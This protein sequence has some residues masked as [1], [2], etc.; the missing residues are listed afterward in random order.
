M[1]ILVKCPKSQTSSQILLFSWIDKLLRLSLKVSPATI[2]RNLFS[3]TLTCDFFSF[4]HYPQPVTMGVSLFTLFCH[5]LVILPISSHSLAL[6]HCTV[7]ANEAPL[8]HVKPATSFQ[9]AVYTSS[10]GSWTHSD[11]STNCRLP[12]TWAHRCQQ[13]AYVAV[14]DRG[15]SNIIPPTQKTTRFCFFGLLAKDGCGIFRIQ[16]SNLSMK[17]W[18][19]FCCDT[20]ERL[21]LFLWFSL[22][23][24]C[25]HESTNSARAILVILYKISLYKHQNINLVSMGCTRHSE[26]LLSCR[27]KM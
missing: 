4:G 19:C 14:I 24:V 22:V 27:A 10:Q 8:R 25:C 7:V 16:M 21:S 18:V 6:P 17:G 2:W 1:G 11:D 13:L 3:S 12:H 20:R 5:S 26:I 9:T 15:E 23:C